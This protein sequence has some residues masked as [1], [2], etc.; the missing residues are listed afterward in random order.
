MYTL[1][2]ALSLFQSFY[3]IEWT[4]LMAGSIIMI[5]P[6]LLVFIIGQRY[7]IEGIQLGAVNGWRLLLSSRPGGLSC[8]CSH[9]SNDERIKSSEALKLF[10]YPRWSFF[11]TKKKKDNT[12]SY[13]EST[14]DTKGGGYT[15]TGC[16]W[17][18]DNRRKKHS[19]ISA[20]CQATYCSTAKLEGC[21]GIHP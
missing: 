4:L 15:I 10:I 6:M 17:L 21:H 1:P 2:V 12:Q 5:A 18:S 20:G 14:D 7:F 8:Y 9:L 11:E 13:A 19:Q 16:K 3:E